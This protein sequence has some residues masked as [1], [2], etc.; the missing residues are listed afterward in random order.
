M[1]DLYAEPLLA[2]ACKYQVPGLETI[3]ENHLCASLNVSNVV[4]VLYL[5]DLYN[6]QQL[7]HR[8]L[9]SIAHN[10]KAVVETEGFFHSLNFSLCQE[11]IRALA[12]VE[13]MDGVQAHSL[14][15]SPSTESSPGR[16]SGGRSVSRDHHPG[17][18]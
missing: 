15:A 17:E 3:C 4:N 10:A 7:K 16:Y 18:A 11:V 13:P 12:G 1:L 5:S 2:I 14:L 9:H 6:A 8:A